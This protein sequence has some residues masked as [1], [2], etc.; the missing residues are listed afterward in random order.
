MTLDYSLLYTLTPR[1]SQKDKPTGPG[2]QQ[3][4]NVNRKLRGHYNTDLWWMV[5]FRSQDDVT[6]LVCHIYD[7]MLRLIDK[8]W[9]VCSSKLPHRVNVWY[10]FS[11]LVSLSVSHYSI[12]IYVLSSAHVWLFWFLW[13]PTFWRSVFCCLSCLVSNFTPMVGR[14]TCHRYFILWSSIHVSAFVRQGKPLDLFGGCFIDCV[15]ILC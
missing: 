11:N 3:C 2:M 7:I 15:C 4:L 6:K 9:S 10:P 14:L 12:A 1:F 5:F 13:H 8:P